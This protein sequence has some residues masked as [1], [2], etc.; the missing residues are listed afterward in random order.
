[1][2]GSTFFVVIIPFE[3]RTI[4]QPMQVREQL[5]RAMT[6]M[7]FEKQDVETTKPNKPLVEPKPHQPKPGQIILTDEKH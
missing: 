3:P 5:K 2:D 1:M 6:D 7:L 4:E